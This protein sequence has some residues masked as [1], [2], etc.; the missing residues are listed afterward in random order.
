MN[1]A[2]HWWRPVELED[3]YNDLTYSI[4]PKT[5]DTL[6]G[7]PGVY[8]FCRQY[9]ESPYPMVYRKSSKHRA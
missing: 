7:L 4:K 2:A 8:M 9:N 1:L 3:G 6:D 5:L